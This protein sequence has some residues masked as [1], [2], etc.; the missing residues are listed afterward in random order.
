[1]KKK[2][3]KNIDETVYFTTLPNKMKVYLI[4]KP[5]FAEKDAYI[6]T[7]FGH[8][9]CLRNIMVNRKKVKIPWGVAHFLEHRM[10]SIHDQDASD[11]FS[12]NGAS[13]NAYTTY[14]KTAYY[15]V[16]ENRFYENLQIL[17]TMMDCFSST[18]KQ[19]ENEKS[20]IIQEANMY[21]E[22]PSFVVMNSLYKNAYHVHPIGIDVIG[23][24]ESILNTDKDIL[25]AVFD[26]FYDPGN[27][28]LVV[29]GDIDPG[30]L[31][32]YLLNHL[33]SRK[34]PKKIAPLSIKEPASIVLKH[35]EIRMSTIR[36]NRL[37]MLLKLPSYEDLKKKDTMYYCYNLIMDYLFASSGK[38]S[39]K[40]LK[41]NILTTLLD[42]SVTSNID[43]DN[44]IF[45]NITNDAEK[46]IQAIRQ[47]FETKNC[48][49]MKQE[50]LES[51]KKCQ[52]GA[53]IKAYE[54]VN[55]VCSNFVYD[56]YS[57]CSGDYFDE[58]SDI[59]KI[60]LDDINEAYENIRQAEVC[61]V[62]VR[63]E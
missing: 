47:F 48:L 62:I 54:S 3:Y 21:K 46:V 56:L 18:E 22:Q 50:E 27:L 39:E 13:C 16:C 30:E 53:T 44:I 20:I 1:M 63:G 58:I 34:N 57:S 4:A 35:E 19:V 49:D 43:L 45:Y 8:F 38:L 28:T 29:A 7:K 25:Q 52:Y 17:L 59:E 32:T 2:K 14:E 41:E 15:F 60:T 5:G 26:T 51:L 6:V 33:L 10:F 42:Y 37:G 36:D 40:W 9:D 31:K 23:T 61:T 24:E 55:S 12:C 11:L